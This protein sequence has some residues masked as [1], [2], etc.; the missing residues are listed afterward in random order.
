MTGG[1]ETL[2]AILFAE[3]QTQAALEC[4]RE[5][6]RQAVDFHLPWAAGQAEALAACF[7]LRLGEL[8]A[9]QRWAQQ[10][11]LSLQGGFN[12]DQGF[13]YSTLARLLLAEHRLE[14]GRAL[15]A[16][17]LQTA[18]GAGR[19]TTELQCC[20]LL[21]LF[22]QQS[23]CKDE[24]RRFTARALQMAAQ[25]DYLRMFLDE[26]AEVRVLLTE[27][28][29]N[30]ADAGLENSD[31]KMTVEKFTGVLLA[32]FDQPSTASTVTGHSKIKNLQSSSP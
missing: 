11:Q 27:F 14:D 3:G 8:Q 23:G 32:A 7:S 28:R 31:I 29:L 6:Y 16:S 5:T 20:I 10:V 18:Q 30:I 21:A 12:I 2:A 17:Q 9:A 26:G 13:E 24:A 19:F 25:Q 22:E 15:L 4:V 1:S